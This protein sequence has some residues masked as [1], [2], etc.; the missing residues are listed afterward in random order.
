MAATAGLGLWLRSFSFHVLVDLTLATL[1][2]GAMLLLL[3]EW[4]LKK[5]RRM[6]LRKIFFSRI[7]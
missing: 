5:G 4:S 3:R 6:A 1:C 7:P 2:Y